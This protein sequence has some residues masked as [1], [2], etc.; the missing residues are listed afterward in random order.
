MILAGG[1][2]EG[3]CWE[4][5]VP[6]KPW[7]Q[8]PDQNEP[9]PAHRAA[10]LVNVQTHYMRKICVKIYVQNLCAKYMCKKAIV[11]NM[12]KEMIHKQ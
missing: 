7:V 1:D 5:K 9:K 3:S 4:D 12:M 10:L 8:Q 2:D 11:Q 6:G